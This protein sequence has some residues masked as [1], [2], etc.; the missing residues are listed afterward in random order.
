MLGL[1]PLAVLSLAA[2]AAAGCDSLPGPQPVDPAPPAATARA[3]VAL[4]DACPADVAWE[5]LPAEWQ[6]GDSVAVLPVRIEAE[7]AGDVD[8]VYYTVA[9]QYR[10]APVAQGRLLAADGFAVTDT[11]RLPRGARGA[12]TVLVTP[13]GP[14]SV[15]GNA[16]RLRL[17]FSGQPLGA[18]ALA[19]LSAPET[20]RP[21]GTLQFTVAVSDPDG[22][23]NVS[24]V[25]ARSDVLG[26]RLPLRDDGQGGDRRAGDGL[27]TVRIQVPADFPAGAFPFR[28]TATDRDGLAAEPIPFTV[29]FTD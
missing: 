2:L 20:F 11:L 6:E 29:T 21:P 9:W 25:E 19:G 23:V 17:T 15:L 18:P 24:D 4:P 26:L 5:A 3:C 27:Y 22:L 8:A 1:R 13:E 14:G 28:L 10:T 7:V 16:S 12:Y